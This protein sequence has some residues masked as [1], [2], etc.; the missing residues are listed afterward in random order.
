[1]PEIHL[2]VFQGPL[3]LLLHLIERDDLDVTSVSLVAVTDQYLNAIRTTE[4]FPPRALA[5]FISI[6]AKLIYLKSRALLPR[7][8]SQALEEDDEVGR[9]LIDMLVEYRRYAAVTTVLGERQEAG[10]RFFTRMAPPPPQPEG[11]GLEGVTT[12]LMRTIMLDVLRRTPEPP[13]VLLPRQRITLSQR[14]SV[15]RSRLQGAGRFSFREAMQECTTRLEVVLS[16]LAILELMKSGEC[17]AVQSETW[18]D[19]EVTAMMPVKEPAIA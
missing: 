14:L 7:D 4:G 12:D 3:E 16:F 15:L 19:I 17:D 9:E 1:M 10:L 6:G 13:R 2:P 8:P 5:E 11:N 18:G